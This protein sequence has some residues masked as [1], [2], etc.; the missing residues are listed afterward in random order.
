M[1]PVWNSSLWMDMFDELLD[2]ELDND[3]PWTFNFNYGMDPNLTEPEKRRGWK[4]YRRDVQAEFTCS[5]CSKW[6]PSG[7]SLI[8]FRYRRRTNGSGTVILRPLK[9]ACRKC[10]GPYELPGFCKEKVKKCLLALISHIK[11]N[12]YGYKSSNSNMD[13]SVKPVWTK[14]HEVSFC[15][16]CRLG[17]C[18]QDRE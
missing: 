16:A 10:Q 12:C 7:R 8:L 4:T 11:K 1:A 18:R 6:W 17:I 13:D 14:P 3:D 5:N 15:E 9:Q 2:T